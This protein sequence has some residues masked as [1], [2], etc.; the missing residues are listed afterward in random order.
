MMKSDCQLDHSLQ[1]QP[2]RLT[3]RHRA[4]DV[5]K[6]FMRVKKVSAIKKIEAPVE[7]RAVTVGPHRHLELCVSPCAASHAVL[8]SIPHHPI[9]RMIPAITLSYDSTPRPEKIVFQSC[10]T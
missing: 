6:N 5:L 4:P 10:S 3:T 8:A 9:T 1:V 2:Q 7:I